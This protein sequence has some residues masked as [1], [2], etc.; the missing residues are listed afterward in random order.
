MKRDLGEVAALSAAPSLTLLYIIIF[1]YVPVGRT[2]HCFS[3]QYDFRKGILGSPW[4]GL[5]TF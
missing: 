4:V 5:E 3:K 1:A 2:D